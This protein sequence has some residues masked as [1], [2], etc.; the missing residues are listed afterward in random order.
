M[1][2]YQ[3]MVGAGAG[4]AFDVNQKKSGSVLAPPPPPDPPPSRA[5][6]GSNRRVMHGYEA[7]T[8]KLRQGTYGASMTPRAGRFVPRGPLIKCH[9]EEQG[10]EAIPGIPE[11][12]TSL[13]SSR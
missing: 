10:D 7:S 13:R 6:E 8:D 2:T 5:G 9:C 12:A 11:I 3:P 4:A 1:N